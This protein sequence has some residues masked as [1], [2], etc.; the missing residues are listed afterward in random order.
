[1]IKLFLIPSSEDDSA[2]MISEGATPPVAGCT[3][4]ETGGR[5]DVEPLWFE[6][7]SVSADIV[8]DFQS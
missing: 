4:R 3:P 5:R 8:L 7:W 2:S 6:S 1:M